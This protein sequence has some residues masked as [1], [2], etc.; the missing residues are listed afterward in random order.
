M[1][2]GRSIGAFAYVSCST[3]ASVTV[4]EALL[5]FIPC[6]GA[7]V[8]GSVLLSGGLRALGQRFHILPGL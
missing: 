5:Y 2:R 7:M 8:A 3:F 1:T 6:L 4:S